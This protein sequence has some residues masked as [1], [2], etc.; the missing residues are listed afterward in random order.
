MNHIG[1]ENNGVTDML[2]KQG[3]GLSLD[4]TIFTMAPVDV[5]CFVENEQRNSSPVDASPLI[6]GHEV[7]FDLGRPG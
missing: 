2:A 6:I 4:S 3:C 7:L 5:A 1:R